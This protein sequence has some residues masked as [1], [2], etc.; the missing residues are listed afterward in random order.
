M[1]FLIK[2]WS[3]LCALLPWRGWIW[4]SLFLYDL[5]C[6][7][8]WFVGRMGDWDSLLK[9]ALL[10]LKLTYPYI[11]PEKR[12][13]KKRRFQTWKPSFLGPF[14]VSFRE[15]LVLS[16]SAWRQQDPNHYRHS[17]TTSLFHLAIGGIVG[18][19]KRINAFQP[20]RLGEACLDHWETRRD[21][22]YNQLIW[23]TW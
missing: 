14:A 18:V 7:A 8:I 1:I 12:P 21:G 10:S 20:G 19:D 22:C 5:F 9:R 23:A 2:L 3:D 16:V 6:L 4:D 13:L 17:N 15:A 11:S